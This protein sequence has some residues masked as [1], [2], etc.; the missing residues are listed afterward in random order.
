M[1][2]HEAVGRRPV[3]RSGKSAL[4]VR[5]KGAGMFFTARDGF[6]RPGEYSDDGLYWCDGKTGTLYHVHAT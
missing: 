4:P 3:C 1:T 5:P 6:S 2:R